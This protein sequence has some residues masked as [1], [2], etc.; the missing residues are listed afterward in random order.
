MSKKNQGN[1]K[2]NNTMITQQ[3]QQ[4]QQAT[5]LNDTSSELQQEQSNGGVEEGSNDVQENQAAEQAPELIKQAET[6]PPVI[7]VKSPVVPQAPVVT[8]TIQSTKPEHADFIQ[9]TE[10]LMLKGTSEQKY[11]IGTM[12]AYIEAMKPGKRIDS[13]TGAKHQYTL[14]RLLFTVIHNHPRDQFKTLWQ[15]VL[16]YFKEYGNGVLGDDAVY[17]FSEAWKYNANELKAF[18]R[19]LDLISLTADAA[20]AQSGL[21]QYDFKRGLSIGFTEEGSS[22]LVNFYKR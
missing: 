6:P 19:L 18:Q 2:G 11:I 10:D 20:T 5:E 13:D 9:M 3:Q 1:Q 7:Q 12:R 16:A 14:W 17:R 4:S 15:L 22:R 8:N 21:K